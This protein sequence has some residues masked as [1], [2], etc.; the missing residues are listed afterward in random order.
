MP[1]KPWL[2]PLALAFGLVTIGTSA[3]LIRLAGTSGVVAVLYRMAIGVLAISPLFIQQ[4]LSR[5]RITWAA[6]WPALLAGV[7]FA[8]DLL[9]WSTGV[10]MSGATNPT[11]LANTAP[12]WVGLGAVVLFREHL[13][14]R[15]WLG[16]VLTMVGAAAV[17]GL[18]AVESVRL[19]LGTLLG[20]LAGMFYGTYFLVTQRGRQRLDVISYFWVSSL[21]ATII[22]GAAALATGQQVVGFSRVTY[23]YL[24][25]LG[26][27]PQAL[28]WLAV[29]YAQGHLPA[30][31]VSPTM[32]GQ[33]VVTA[34]LAGPVL[35]EWISPLEAASGLVVLLGIWLVHRSRSSAAGAGGA[36]G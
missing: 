10:V 27:G 34:I 31:I 12:L 5:S 19:G 16:L 17:L 22:L 26:L 15:F 36:G 3:I 11:L 30:S 21:S 25:A 14:G 28:G 23:M 29:N 18:D 6:I 24:L 33:P 9:A 7:F 2:P 4:R 35:G 1:S 13:G 8:G 20:L 32:L